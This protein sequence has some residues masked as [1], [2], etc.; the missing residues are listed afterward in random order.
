MVPRSSKEPMPIT[1][2]CH[3]RAGR[4]IPLDLG[5]HQSIT[6]GLR[7]YIAVY[8]GGCTVRH[9]KELLHTRQIASHCRTS[10]ITQTYP[11]A[12]S[13]PIL[14]AVSP[15]STEGH[16]LG[17]DDALRLVRQDRSTGISIWLL[18]GHGPSVANQALAIADLQPAKQAVFSHDQDLPRALR[19]IGMCGQQST[20]RM[21]SFHSM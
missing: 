7:F 1:P 18:H 20:V 5:S 15:H 8:N 11:H 13:Q 19:R 2:W 4:G 12:H 14:C 10:S 17:K 6:D 21:N 9:P 3:S 16:D